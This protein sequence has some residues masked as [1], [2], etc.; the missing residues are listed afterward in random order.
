MCD[1]FSTDGNFEEDTTEI[2]DCIYCE[3]SGIESK[4]KFDNSEI[5]DTN[6]SE[7]NGT[8]IHLTSSEQR[9]E[10]EAEKKYEYQNEK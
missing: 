10:D 4:L 7:C 5:I 8:G 3:G 1:Y 9:A 6:C 2:S